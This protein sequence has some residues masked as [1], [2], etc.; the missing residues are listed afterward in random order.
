MADKDQKIRI[1]ELPLAQDGPEM[2]NIKAGAVPS[3]VSLPD[4]VPEML[5]KKK[6]I[7]D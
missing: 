6:A 4:V 2:K 5:K 1:D 7:T 3:H